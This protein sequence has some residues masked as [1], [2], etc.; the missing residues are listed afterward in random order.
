MTFFTRRICAAR[1]PCLG[2]NQLADPQGG[3]TITL[4][5]PVIMWMVG[6]LISG[7]AALVHMAK[8]AMDR[9]FTALSTSINRLAVYEHNLTRTIFALLTRLHPDKAQIIVETMN[10]QFTDSIVPQAQKNGAAKWT[11]A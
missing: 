11:S 6:G 3:I 4:T 7:L 10:E 9:K 8:R 2:A 1:L 5:P